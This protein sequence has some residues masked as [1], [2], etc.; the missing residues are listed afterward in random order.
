VQV[1]TRQYSFP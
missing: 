1:T